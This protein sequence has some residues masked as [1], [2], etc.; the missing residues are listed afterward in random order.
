MQYNCAETLFVTSSSISPEGGHQ[1]SLDGIYK[2]GGKQRRK[3]LVQELPSF[4]SLDS[5]NSFK[6]FMQTA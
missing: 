1:W 5:P 4:G 3:Q 2:P 6:V